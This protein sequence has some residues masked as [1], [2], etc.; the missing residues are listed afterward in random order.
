MRHKL[1]TFAEHPILWGGVGVLVGAIG[2]AYSMKVIFVA[3][4]CIFAVAVIRTQFFEGKKLYQKGLG[5]LALI[6]LIGILLFILWRIT[7]NP[8]EPAT[9][10]QIATA[11]INKQHEAIQPASGVPSI[12][13][14]KASEPDNP[15]V[16]TKRP[17]RSGHTR[18]KL[19][20]QSSTGET[21]P[22]SPPTTAR[23]ILSQKSQISTR[24]DA[25]YQTEVTV[26]TTVEFPTLKLLIRCDKP[27]VDGNGGLNAIMMMTSQGVIKDHPNF[28]ILTYQSAVPP[29]GP[30]NPIIVSLWSKEPVKCEAA[31]F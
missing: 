6:A 7:P 23:L 18:R 5:N 11:V 24:E 2:V 25:P 15:D 16:T 21:E 30:K 29:F 20:G 26:Q 3:A 27:L 12:A 13:P 8:K 19:P 31:T 14:K 9:A 28:Y 1:W 10:E 4:G 17:K 22:A